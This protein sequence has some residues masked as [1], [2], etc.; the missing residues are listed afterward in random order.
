MRPKPTSAATWFGFWMRCK[1][2]RNPPGKIAGTD[3]RWK[4]ERLQSDRPASHAGNDIMIVRGKNN[5]TG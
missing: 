4:D 1:I 5:T 3:E 2:D